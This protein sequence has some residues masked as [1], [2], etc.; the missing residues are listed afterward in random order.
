MSSPDPEELAPLES[1]EAVDEDEPEGE[2]DEE[3]VSERLVSAEVTAGSSDS[4][5]QTGGVEG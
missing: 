3:A 5:N 2:E 1:L 4:E